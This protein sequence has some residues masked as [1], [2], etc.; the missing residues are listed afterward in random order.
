MKPNEKE[1]TIDWKEI[2]LCIKLTLTFLFL[3][4]SPLLIIIHSEKIAKTMNTSIGVAIIMGFATILGLG[5]IIVMLLENEINES[6]SSKPN[7]KDYVTCIELEVQGREYTIT[8]ELYNLLE[9]RG[10]PTLGE[11]PSLPP[12]PKRNSQA[13]THINHSIK[14][15]ENTTSRV[16]PFPTKQETP[17]R[18]NK[19]S[20]R[21]F[22]KNHIQRMDDLDY[23][24]EEIKKHNYPITPE[25]KSLLR[26]GYRNKNLRKDF[27]DYIRNN[28]PKGFTVETFDLTKNTEASGVNPILTDLINQI[29]THGDKIVVKQQG[30][31]LT[32]KATLNQSNQNKQGHWGDF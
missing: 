26:N 14:G 3:V 22:I 2:K 5:I 9:K 19:E 25:S 16:T 24:E 20:M 6:Q 32:I 27:D 31:Q 17:K 8:K 18:A 29:Q 11:V 21:E 4:I 10:V 30:Q 28:P 23:I 15:K 1:K 12:N 13:P 7:K